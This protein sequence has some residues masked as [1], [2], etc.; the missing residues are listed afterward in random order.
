[1]NV[2][3]SIS[4]S[5][6]NAAQTRLQA[7]AHNIAN[8]ETPGFSRQEVSQ[9]TIAGGGTSVSVSNS[10]GSA[11]LETDMVQQLQAKNSF[12]ANLSVFK[13]HNAVLGTLLN[14]SA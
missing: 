13:T 4:L 10:A 5:G 14:I 3:S 2:T 12:L 1:M 6:M 7:S 11:N 9:S 8:L